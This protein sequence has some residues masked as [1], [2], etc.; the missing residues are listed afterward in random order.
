MKSDFRLTGLSA[1]KSFTCRT[2]DKEDIFWAKTNMTDERYKVLFHWAKTSYDFWKSIWI[3][4][5]EHDGL[6][7]DGTP[8]NPIVTEIREE[9]S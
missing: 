8:I 2:L 3:A 9:F 7:E 4:V 6:Y 5:I 1:P